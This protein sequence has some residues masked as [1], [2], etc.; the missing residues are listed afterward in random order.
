MVRAFTGATGGLPPRRT[1]RVPLPTCPTKPFALLSLAARVLAFDLHPPP[2]VRQ[3]PRRLQFRRIAALHAIVYGRRPGRFAHPRSHPLMLQDAGLAVDRGH[4]ALYAYRKLVRV[5]LG[6]GELG[7]DCRLQL[8]IAELRLDRIPRR[9]A[10]RGRPL[11]YRRRLGSGR[12]RSGGHQS[13]RHPHFRICHYPLSCGDSLLFSEFCAKVR[14]SQRLF[15]V[16]CPNRSCCKAKSW[17]QEEFLLRAPLK[18]G[19]CVPPVKIYSPASRSGS[20]CCAKCCPAPCWPNL[21]WRASCWAPVAV[22]SSWWCCPGAFARPPKPSLPPPPRR[23]PNSAPSA[24]SWSGPSPIIWAIGPSFVSASTRSCRARA[25]PPCGISAPPRSGPLWRCR[26]ATRTSI[27]PASSAPR[28]ARRR[29]SAGPRR[30][31]AR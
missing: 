26:A 29:K 22:A 7:A 1:Q 5:D 20:P 19:L 25:T 13:C 12:P 8:H 6:F 17:V 16:R 10:A 23:F 31:P 21:A 28:C 30:I 11:M 18:D 14:G 4:S 27:S 9:R 24:S 15:R 2:A 3:I